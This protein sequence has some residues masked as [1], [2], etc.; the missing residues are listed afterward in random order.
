M[1]ASHAAV[2]EKVLDREGI[3][4]WPRQR[5]LACKIAVAPHRKVP[6]GRAL[7]RSC[8]AGRASS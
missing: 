2:I 3:W 5:S 6:A 4:I 1:R 7:R 8:G